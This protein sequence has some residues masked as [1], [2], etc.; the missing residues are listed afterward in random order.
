MVKRQVRTMKLRGGQIVSGGTPLPVRHT[1]V[2]GLPGVAIV[3]NEEDL[4]LQLR[5]HASAS[6]PLAVV[7]P[8]QYALAKD[9]ER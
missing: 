2:P 8:K 4:L 7:A 9:V 5:R 6:V 3:A 1:L